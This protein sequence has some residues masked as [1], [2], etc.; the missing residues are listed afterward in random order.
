MITTAQIYIS[1]KSRVYRRRASEL[2][3]ITLLLFIPFSSINSQSTNEP[4][5]LSI[6][7]KNILFYGERNKIQISVKEVPFEELSF[8]CENAEI[9]KTLASS[10]YN[11]YPLKSSRIIAVLEILPHKKGNMALTII[12]KDTIIETI[13]FNVVIPPVVAK[14]GCYNGGFIPHS[15]L[16]AA[17]NVDITP[18]YS[19]FKTLSFSVLTKGEENTELREDSYSDKMT[20]KQKLIIAN[21]RRGQKVYFTNIKGVDSEGRIFNVDPIMFRIR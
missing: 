8:K 10:R 4:L 2:L 14:V 1:T 16:K 15:T 17:R 5:L 21:L 19:N 12:H 3:L 11:V 20:P 9:R 18:S 6:N 7:S 13:Q